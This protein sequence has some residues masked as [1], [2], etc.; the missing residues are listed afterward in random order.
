IYAEDAVD[1]TAIELVAV[2]AGAVLE[3]HLRLFEPVRSMGGPVRA[4]AVSTSGSPPLEMPEA[5]PSLAPPRALDPMQSAARRYVR[6]EV[7]RLLLEHTSAVTRG[8]REGNLYAAL[9]SEIDATREKYRSRFG[10]G[11]DYLD[12]ELVRT[13][14]LNDPSLLGR[15]YP[16]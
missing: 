14:A 15:D 6:S 4:V 12:A 16:A 11:E 3:N 5:I 10:S 2:M 8:R 1:T 9:R 7:A 13:L